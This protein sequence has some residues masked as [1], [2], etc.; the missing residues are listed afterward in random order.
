[1]SGEIAKLLEALNRE[2]R[3]H[4]PAPP[5]TVVVARNQA[6]LDHAE[7]Q[8]DTGGLT[9]IVRKLSG[10]ATSWPPPSAPSLP[11]PEPVSPRPALA[12]PESS[13]RL[14]APQKRRSRRTVDS[15]TRP[16]RYPSGDA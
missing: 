10:D 14:T 11:D 5:V 4:L 3:E 2:L 15:F 16:L 6:E 8:P 9:V 12:I 7:S 13:E 1:V